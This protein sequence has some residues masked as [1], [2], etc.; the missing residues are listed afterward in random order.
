[1]GRTAFGTLYPALFS[2]TNGDNPM[3]FGIIN[4]AG[5][6]RGTYL[7]GFFDKDLFRE[8]ILRYIRS[9]KGLP[10]PQTHFDYAQF[11]TRELDRLADLIKTSIN[12]EA[13]ERKL[14]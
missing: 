8:N 12:M 3:N 13:I 2:V 10:E 1:M 9:E 5:T 4:Q 14:Q 6:V 11:R 7:H